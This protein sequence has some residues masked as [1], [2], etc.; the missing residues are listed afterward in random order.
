MKP[1]FFSSHIHL[2]MSLAIA[3]LILGLASCRKAIAVDP[4]DN[5]LVAD[6]V[7]ADSSGATAAVLGIYTNMMNYSTQ[8]KFGNGGLGLF[9]GLSADE[10]STTTMDPGEL[11]LYNNSISPMNNMHNASLWQQAYQLI[12]QVNVCIEQLNKSAY[13]SAT[14]Q[15]QLLGEAKCLRAFCYLQLQNIYGEVP[16]VLTS[17]YRENAV[18]PRSDDMN[19]I[20]QIELDL[21]Q[22]EALTVEKLD[23]RLRISRGAVQALKARF[24]LYQ[25]NWAEAEKFAG[26]VIDNPKFELQASFENIFKLNSAESIWQLQ[27][28]MQAFETLDGFL[29]VPYL[30]DIIPSYV[31][32]NTFIAQFEENDLR[33]TFYF[34]K[35]TVGGVDYFYPYKYRNGY[36]GWQG[37]PGEGVTIIRLAEMY[38][39]RAEARLNQNNT[40]GAIADLNIIHM[41]AGLPEVVTTS[42]E[43]TMD[44]IIKERQKELCFE[45]GH[46]WFDLKRWKKLDSVLAPLKPQ[47][48]TTASLFP[49]PEFERTNNPYLTQNEG[50]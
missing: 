21:D 16:L 44:A 27:P 31:V 39:I 4:P 5:T 25:G 30:P 24:Y 10:L 38:L 33:K 3:A 32:A 2:A 41:R 47:W 49:V 34:N 6:Q 42:N 29:Y 37:A 26:A 43:S 23:Q 11:E 20:K 15:S 28:V 9:L 50:Y 13:L 1:K 46:R 8:F 36:S 35:N 17:D 19:I 48:K 7:F 45:W 22:A 18:M 40:E 12:H 14:L